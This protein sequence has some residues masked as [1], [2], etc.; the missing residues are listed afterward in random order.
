MNQT[1]TAVAGIKV[2]HWTDLEARTGCTVILCPEEGCVASAFVL[3]GSPGSRELALLEPEKTVQKIHALLLTGGSAF[4]LA[5]ATGVVD[6]LEQKGIGLQTPACPVP[7]VPAAVIFDLMN[8]NPKRRPGAEEGFLAADSASAEPHATGQV[9]AGSGALIGK[10]LGFEHAA[11]GGLGAAVM[12]V[13]E[14]TVA[15]LSVSNAVG[16]IYE[17]GVLVAGSSSPFRERAQENLPGLFVQAGTNTT[18]V[19]VA[20]D[21][22]LTKA[23]AKALAQ[24]AHIGIATVTRPSHTIHDGDTSFVLSTGAV[25]PPPMMALGIAVQQ[26]VAKA[27]IQGVRE[28]NKS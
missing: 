8:G 25:T 28:A 1:L 11:K 17:D 16:D 7:I 19:A 6:W 18:L 24:S 3:G 10:Y 2:G 13:G 27:L 23:E 21:A 14:A 4:G 12:R 9:G 20:T 22:I 26:V 15:A 5:A